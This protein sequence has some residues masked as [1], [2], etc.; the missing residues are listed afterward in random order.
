MDLENQ[1]GRKD[2]NDYQRKFHS[3]T[4]GLSEKN[5]EYLST[6]REK[7]VSKILREHYRA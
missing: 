6:L 4:I 2:I 5:K 3:K 7:I 1:N